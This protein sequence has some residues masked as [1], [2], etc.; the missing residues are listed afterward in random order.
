MRYEASEWRNMFFRR[1]YKYIFLLI[2]LVVLYRPFLFFGSYQLNESVG[3]VFLS[4]MFGGS[5]SREKIEIVL[6]VTSLFGVMIMNILFG[7]YICKD[8]STNGEYIFSREHN[9]GKWFMRKAFGLGKYCVLGTVIYVG[10]YAIGSIMKS[11]KALMMSDVVVI[12]ATAVMIVEFAYLSTLLINVLAIR[13]GTSLAFVITYSIFIVSEMI[14]FCLQGMK[15]NT[16]VKVLHYV[17]PMSNMTISWNYSD[18]Y[19][20]WSMIYFFILIMTV[21]FI[22]KNV[23]SR[24]EIGIKASEV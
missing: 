13:F 14:T 8:F 16:L 7:D 5:Y 6:S 20:C 24:C 10:L 11:N 12:G 9:K 22:G 3:G 2:P 19:V 1:Q 21:L 15:E 18:E 4:N 17:N 23:A